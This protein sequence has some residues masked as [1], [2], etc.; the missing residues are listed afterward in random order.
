MKELLR[1][2]LELL[3]LGEFKRGWGEG[4]RTL[5]NILNYICKI[6]IHFYLFL[7]FCIFFL[8]PLLSFPS[9]VGHTV[10][11][12]TM[13]CRDGCC[14]CICVECTFVEFCIVCRCAY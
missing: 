9:I 7:S 10:E 6:F 14:V 3:G 11:E 2:V 12:C 5:N 1:K 13:D 8:V 4:R